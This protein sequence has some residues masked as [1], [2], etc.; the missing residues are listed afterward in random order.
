MSEKKST[1]IGKLNR[2]MI[3]WLNKSS[4]PEENYRNFCSCCDRA[5]VRECIKNK[6]L[7]GLYDVQRQIDRLLIVGY[8][9]YLEE[10]GEYELY[11]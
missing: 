7:C 1:P 6:Y 3:K 5:V 8:E 4:T 10:I 11:D 2:Q 9:K